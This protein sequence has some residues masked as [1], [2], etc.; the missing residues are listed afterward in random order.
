MVEGQNRRK[1][2][3]GKNQRKTIQGVKSG[4]TVQGV[5]IRKIPILVQRVKHAYTDIMHTSDE[6][7]DTLVVSL[8]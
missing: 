3:Q 5:S 4:K 1:T 7:E 2:V 6:N 8:E